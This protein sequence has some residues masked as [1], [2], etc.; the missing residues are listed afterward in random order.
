MRISLKC[1]LSVLSIL[2]QALYFKCI[3][4]KRMLQFIS[5]KVQLSAN[6]F[7]HIDWKTGGSFCLT[8]VTMRYISQKQC[9]ITGRDNQSF[10]R[11]DGHTDGLK[12]SVVKLYLGHPYVI[13]NGWV[14]SPAIL[15]AIPCS[16]WLPGQLNDGGSMEYDR[17]IEYSIKWKLSG[18]QSTDIMMSKEALP[19]IVKKQIYTYIDSIF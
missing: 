6:S 9:M 10:S 18:V 19:I 13:F 4:H 2:L 12:Y 14:F 1:K 15:F 5:T 3:I 17:Q 16:C 11:F 7:G 8:A